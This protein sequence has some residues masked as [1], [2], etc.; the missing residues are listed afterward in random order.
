MLCCR[1][2][3]HYPDEAITQT[4]LERLAVPVAVVGGV[5]FSALLWAGQVG[6]G[7]IGA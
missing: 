6:H 2:G 4:K 1:A 7:L 5:A 3:R